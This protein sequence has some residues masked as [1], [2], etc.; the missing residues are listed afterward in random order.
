[1]VEIMKH[2]AVDANVSMRRTASTG[3]GHMKSK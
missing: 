2:L 1:M 3:Y